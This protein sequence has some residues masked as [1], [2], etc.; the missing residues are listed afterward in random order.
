MKADTPWIVFI[1]TARL[2]KKTFADF[3]TYLIYTLPLNWWMVDEVGEYW[4]I[5][6]VRVVTIHIFSR[7]LHGKLYIFHRTR[8]SQLSSSIGKIHA[9]SIAWLKNSFNELMWTQ[10]SGKCVP[11]TEYRILYDDDIII[12]NYSQPFPAVS[13]NFSIKRQFIG[14]MLPCT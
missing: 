14:S 8:S 13:T 1:A 2:K 9:S 7:T 12:N 10:P 4:Q 3:G 5:V 6:C 11:K